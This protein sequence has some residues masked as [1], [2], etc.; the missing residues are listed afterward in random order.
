MPEPVVGIFP[1][2]DNEFIDEEKLKDWLVNDLKKNR[3]RYRL[4]KIGYQD[5][6]FVLQVVPD[7]LILFRIFDN[8][9]G[10][11]IANTRI[12]ILDPPQED[13]TQTGEK[14]TFHSEIFFKPESIQTFKLPIK[15]LIQF[16]DRKLPAHFYLIL[17]DRGSFEKEFSDR[18]PLI[19]QHNKALSEQRNDGNWPT[20]ESIA[21]GFP[22]N[23]NAIPGEPVNIC[24]PTLMVAVGSFDNLEARIL[25]AVVHVLKCWGQNKKVIFEAAKWESETWKKHIDKFGNI[26]VVLRLK[27][28]SGEVD[29]N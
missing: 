8:I 3:G 29:L 5:E 16:Y 25:E 19:Q 14:V 18:Y 6:N 24:Y 4:R 28:A 26:K 7:S 15:E 2:S 12:T 13:V 21:A 20:G 22:P 17:G 10:S 9:V 27:G 11:A 23:V 1:H